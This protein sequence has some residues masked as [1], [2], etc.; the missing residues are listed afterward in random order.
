MIEEKEMREQFELAMLLRARIPGEVFTVSVGNN[1]SVHSSGAGTLPFAT[2]VTALKGIG[3]R[4]I[5]WSQGH[6]LLQGDVSGM[7]VWFSTLYMDDLTPN[8]VKAMLADA[9]KPADVPA[10]GQVGAKER[11][12]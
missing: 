2:A 12:P 3:A 9:L 5:E 8:Q 6:S 7:A 11:M 1:P 10:P 4:H